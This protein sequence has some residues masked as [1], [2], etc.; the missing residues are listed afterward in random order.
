M[1]S[2]LGL[3]HKRNVCY[4]GSARGVGS[5]PIRGIVEHVTC[6]IGD[7]DFQLFFLVLEGTMPYCIMGL[8]QMRRFNCVVDVG[9]NSLIFGGKDGLSI[10]FLPRE[11]AAGVTSAMM[12][13]SND[14]ASDMP[15]Q[16]GR[17]SFAEQEQE[18][19][20]RKSRLRSFMPWGRKNQGIDE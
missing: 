1:V 13:H 10:P 15:E 9:E 12:S 19:C 14:V 18:V 8:D 17:S 2:L 7:V 16:E 5:S 4:Q 3:E 20:R 6:V 11:L